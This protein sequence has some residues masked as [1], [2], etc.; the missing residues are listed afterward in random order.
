MLGDFD[1]DET[2]DLLTH[3][4]STGQID[5]HLIEAAQIRSSST[6]GETSAEQTVVGV[7]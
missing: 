1:G 3:D 4:S 2:Y 7:R 6:I 5:I